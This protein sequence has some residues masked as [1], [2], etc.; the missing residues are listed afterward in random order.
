MRFINIDRR[1][2][3]IQGDSKQGCIELLQGL[4]VGGILFQLVSNLHVVVDLEL[5]P[6]TL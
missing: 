2:V 6:N 3:V 1:A 5:R 4:S